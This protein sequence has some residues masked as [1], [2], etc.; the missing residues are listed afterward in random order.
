MSQA[1]QLIVI[2]GDE[3]LA[4]FRQRL[5]GPYALQLLD[6]A[7]GRLLAL[8]PVGVGKTTWLARIIQHILTETERY[9]L[10]IV[11]IPRWDIL[12]ELRIQ[13]PKSLQAVV[14][15]PRP[16]R[17]CGELDAD[18]VQFEQHGC[19]S[20]G[21]EQ[22]CDNC[23]RRKGCSWPNQYGER[24]RG[25]RLI[26]ATQQHLLVNPQFIARVQNFTQATRALVLID[27][28]NFLIRCAERIIRERD[29]ERFVRAQEDVLAADNKRKAV[30]LRWLERS[31]LVTLAST[32]D[33]RECWQFP[34][35]DGT[36]A[37]AVQRRGRQMFGPTFRFLGY[38]LHH[39]A[40]SDSCSRER[41]PTGDIRFAA[42][43]DLGHEDFIIFSGSIAPPLAHYRLDPNYS[44]PAL[45]SPFEHYRFE[46]SETRWY[47]LAFL[48]GAAKFYPHNANRVL[49]FFAAM[50]ARNIS[51]GKRTLLVSRKKFFRLCRTYLRKKLA[52]LGVGPVKIVTGH[53]QR[54]DLND[55]QTLPLINYGVAGLNCFQHY[56]AAYCLNSFYVTEA[57]VAQ[58]LQDIDPVAASYPLHIQ[59]LGEPPQRRVKVSLPDARQPLLPFLAEWVLHQ[60][61]DDVVVQ[62]V[63]RVRPFTRPREVITFHMGSLPGVRY[64]YQ[65]RTLTQARSFF[66]VVSTKAAEASSR[67]ERA[68]RLKALGWSKRHIAEQLD[69]SISSV[70]RYLSDRGDQFA[71]Y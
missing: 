19:G 50:I 39:L 41:L 30:S 9:D 55:P 10:I 26:L 4:T 7:R 35:V 13:L 60:K 49:D 38:D 69:V 67:A 17:R 36:W 29:L 56:E 32:A 27:E 28:S 1:T 23:P 37:T 58:A 65:F 59:C 45:V 25:A 11:L 12:H 64:T 68:Q 6:Q 15:T 24:L 61:E 22:L 47:N 40:H 21:R 57:T 62:A 16:R 31:R 63:G 71:S 33:L 43:P 34:W 18:W 14:L 54:H 52:E 46:H 44:Q 42:L 66:G 2:T 48:A 5:T 51:E 3:A 53:W 20:L 70:K 8:L